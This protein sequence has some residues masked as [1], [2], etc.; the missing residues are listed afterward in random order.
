MGHLEKYQ[1]HKSK[2]DALTKRFF[3]LFT[4]AG[5]AAPQVD[6]I[7]DLFIPEG[8]IIKNVSPQKE[9]Y[10]LSQF[11]EPRRK[12][13]TDDSLIEFEEAEISERTDI[14]GNIAQ[15]FCLYYKKEFF[16]VN[17]LKRGG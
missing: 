14:F 6:E 4:N 10:N 5:G 2:I 15:R 8:T 13:L 12:L 7:F 17:P 16:R 3:S 1:L 11:V 9:V